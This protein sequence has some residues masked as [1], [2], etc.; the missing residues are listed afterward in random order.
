M[1]DLIVKPMQIGDNETIVNKLISRNILNL[2]HK[3]YL[4]E[5][6][7]NDCSGKEMYFEHVKETVSSISFFI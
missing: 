4:K 6:Y 1:T 7:L 5:L 3:N 2:K